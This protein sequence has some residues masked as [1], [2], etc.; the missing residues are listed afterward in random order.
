MNDKILKRIEEKG[1][2]TVIGSILLIVLVI[3]VVAG[4]Y[5]YIGDTNLSGETT[6]QAQLQTKIEG[7]NLILSHNGGE[8][9]N[10]DKLSM[11]INNESYSFSDTGNLKSGQS[12]QETLP[13]NIEKEKVSIIYDKDVKLTETEEITTKT[14]EEKIVKDW[15]DLN[16]IKDNLQENYILMNNLDENSAGYN[17]LVNTDNGWKPI[18]DDDNIFKGQLKGN[19]YKIKD[20]YIENMKSNVGLFGYTGKGCIIKNLTIKNSEVTG[21]G[22]I[23]TLIGTQNYGDIKNIKIIN[24][25]ITSDDSQ[26]G[27]MVGQNPHGSIKDSSV[28]DTKI[29]SSYSFSDSYGGL[30]GY[31]EGE[32]L[33]SHVENITLNDYGMYGGGLVGRLSDTIENSYAIDISF[34]S[35][36]SGGL[37]GKL[38]GDVKN[39]YVENVDFNGEGNEIGG[40]IS[41]TAGGNVENSYAITKNLNVSN[42]ERIGGLIGKNEDTIVKNSYAINENIHTNNVNDTGGLVGGNGIDS[43]SGEIINCYAVSENITGDSTDTGELI[44][45]NKGE[46]EDSFSF[47]NS[48][49]YDLIGNTAYSD[50]SGRVMSVSIDNLK[51]IR[52]YTDNDYNGYDNLEESWDIKNVNDSSDRDN[53][54]IWNI[55]N[56]NTYPFLSYQE[57]VYYL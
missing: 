50:E 27:G 3:G 18:G 46:V 29:E 2:S 11:T 16:N 49:D 44:G 17:D 30:I 8:T 47:E 10:L 37:I 31:S 34:N 52:L 45:R 9:V 57:E 35:N 22:E 42:G 15:H 25:K 56:G 7:D 24:G 1:I 40:L 6:P 26:V 21:G 23:G 38:G 48:H 55:D 14:V 28:I 32:I 43:D 13:Y 54:H 19:D 33:N 51:N 39:S 53:S 12:I 5:S 41:E 4:I 20:L 36:V